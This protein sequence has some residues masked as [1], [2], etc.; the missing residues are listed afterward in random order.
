[1]SVVVFT[2]IGLLLVALQTTVFMTGPTWPAAPDLYFVLVAWLACRVD[3]LRGLIVLLPLCWMLDVVSGVVIGTYPGICLGGFFLLRF[4]S[5]RMPVKESLYRIPLIGVVYLFVSWIVYLMLNLFEPDALIPWS[6][7]L[8]LLRA[9]LVALFA[10]P[11]FRF[12]EFIKGRLEGGL[13]PF[14]KLRVRSGNRYR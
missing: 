12:F 3:L 5:E 13:N 2:G 1:M 10:L 8:M 4:M 6:W 11:L 7:L 14:Q 9:T